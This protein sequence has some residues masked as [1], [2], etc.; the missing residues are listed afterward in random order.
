MKRAAYLAVFLEFLACYFTTSP[1]Y[2]SDTTS[3]A[4]DAVLHAQGREAQFWDF[5]HLLWRPWAY[6]GHLLFGAWFARSFGD[7]PQQAVARFL[8]DTN[9]V[10]SALFLLLLVFL[11][12]KVARPAIAAAVT[13]AISCSNPFLN[14]CHSG[15]SY[16]PALLFSVIAICLLV[17]AAERKEQSRWLALLAGASFTIACALWFPFS[18][19]GLGLLLVL[20]LWPSPGSGPTSEPNSSTT[21]EAMVPERPRRIRLLGTFL[22]SLTVTLLVLFAAGAAAQGVSS[23]SQLSAWISGSGHGWSQSKTALRAITGV[24]RIVWDFGGD[25]ILLKRWLFRDPY[26]P[27]NLRMVLFSMGWKLAVFY[28]GVAAMLWALFKRS[29]LGRDRRDLLLIFAGAGLPLLAFA[30]VLFEPSS[31]ERFMPLLPF[32][33]IGLAA[34]LENARSHMVASACVAILLVSSVVVNLAQKETVG[35]TRLAQAKAR[36][37]ALNQV[38]QPGALV[39]VLTFNDDLSGLPAIRPLDH[40]LLTSRFKVSDTVEMATQRML[41]WR[42]EFAERALDQWAGNHEVWISERLLASRPEARWLWV[43]A[44]DPRI[45]WADLPATFSGLEFDAKVLGGN[46]GF[47]RVAQSENNR[48]RLATGFAETGQ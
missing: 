32:A 29:Q 3:Y 22:A 1:D 19:T 20:F 37:E 17:E 10:C 2:L 34:V 42:A 24:A 23:I 14:Y 18:F 47:L 8:I 21:P 30:I 46:D 36:M 6:A 43:E 12:G 27:V 41:R 9:F 28:L 4:N 15:A 25:T 31:P 26:N 35:D 5:G 48:R 38:V 45:R 40:S 33:G 16:I 7:T 11:L 44:D 39:F 13:F